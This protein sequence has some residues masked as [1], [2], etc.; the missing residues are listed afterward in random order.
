[1]KYQTLRP[2]AFVGP[3]AAETIQKLYP[4]EQRFLPIEVPANSRLPAVLA[5]L[6]PLGFMGAV[7]SGSA[8]FEAASLVNRRDRNVDR[9][10]VVDAVV[11]HGGT[12][13]GHTLE[14]ALINTLEFEGFRGYGA[15]AVILGG[16]SVAM[17]ATQLARQGFKTITIAAPDR[18]AAEKLA[19]LLPAGVTSHPLTFEEPRL[20]DVLER[21][22]LI[23]HCSSDARLNPALLQPY[24]TLLEACEETNLAVALE[25]TGG[26]VIP[27]PRVAAHALAAQLEF[28]TAIKYDPKLFL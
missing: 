20:H 26:N 17:A 28:V 9:D 2:V 15:H 4:L 18:P 13:G 16:G 27:Y 11:V 24:H 19:R 25:R 10:G 6:E 21:A 12:F 5:G 14:D 23:V 3:A 1:M 7:I 8:Q 22:D